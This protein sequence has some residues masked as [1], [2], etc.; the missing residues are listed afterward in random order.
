M[1][2]SLS[3]SRHLPE[4]ALCLICRACGTAGEIYARKPP[5]V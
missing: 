1:T 3:T 2:R 4:R 5:E